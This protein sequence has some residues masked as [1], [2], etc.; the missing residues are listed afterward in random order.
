MIKGYIYLLL[1]AISWSVAG[2]LIRFNGQSGLMIAVISSIIAIIFNILFNHDKLI[3]NKLV[4]CIGVFQ[5]IS[6]ITFNY[7][8]QLTTVGNAIVLQYTSMIFVLIYQCIDRKTLPKAKQLGIIFMVA[9]GMILFFLDTIST[10][11]MIGNMLAIISGAFFGLQFYM[12]TKSKADA[13]TSNIISYMIS[14]S[15][16]GFVFHDFVTVK[17]VEWIMMILSGII[18]TG[19]GG[20]FF[21]KGIQ[22][23][24][25]FTANIICMSEV[26][27]SPLWAFLIFHET[28]GNISLIGAV[29]IISGIL[30]NMCLELQ[31]GVKKKNINQ[32]IEFKN[33]LGK[34]MRFC[35]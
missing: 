12:N 4:I 2:V 6:G 22:I 16:I 10:E 27:F 26:L 3:F 34:E 20:L 18:V 5:F 9:F 28:V 35:K 30:M 33:H 23:V 24:N 32:Y 19:M 14:I 15:F 8:N 29:I 7:A 1:T 21:Q 11:G 17:P 31:S 13:H 25:A